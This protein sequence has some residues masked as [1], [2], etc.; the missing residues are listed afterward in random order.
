ML[1][2]AAD[3]CGI[4]IMPQIKKTQTVQD[5]E[6]AANICGIHKYD[7]CIFLWEW[8]EWKNNVLIMVR[9]QSMVSFRLECTC[10][11]FPEQS[12]FPLNWYIDWQLSYYICQSR[13]LFGKQSIRELSFFTGRRE[14]VCDGRSPIFSDP[15]FVYVQKFWAPPLPTG[16]KFWSPL[17]TPQKIMVPPQTHPPPLGVKSDSSLNFSIWM[18]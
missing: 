4:L 14:S 9:L 15:P 6:Y 12:N 16:K 7:S 17:W 11:L 1:V 5:T 13:V 2:Y 8:E 10:Q 18:F 3:I